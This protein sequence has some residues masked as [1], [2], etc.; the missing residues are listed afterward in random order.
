[1]GQPAGVIQLL[2]VGKM[3][4]YLVSGVVSIT[5]VC[6]SKGEPQEEDSVLPE[7]SPIKR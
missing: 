2:G 6:E 3:P 1:M 5:V 4:T 7:Q